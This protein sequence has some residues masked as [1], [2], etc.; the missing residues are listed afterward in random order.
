MLVVTSVLA[1][2]AVIEYY[3]SILFFARGG[4][5]NE[6]PCF[7]ND[8]HAKV[9]TYSL[10]S[11]LSSWG[12]ST[13]ALRKE[14]GG[15]LY[16]PWVPV[17]V[18]FWLSYKWLFY[19]FVMAVYPLYCLLVACNENR[20]K[21]LTGIPSHFQQNLL[22]PSHWMALWW[23]NYI[24]CNDM[25]PKDCKSLALLKQNTLLAA[26]EE[27]NL[28]TIKCIEGDVVVKNANVEGGM[29]IHFFKSEKYGGNC[30]IQC[31]PEL[32]ESLKDLLPLECHNPPP[33]F[34]VV[35]V[36]PVGNELDQPTKVISCV[37]E[38]FNGKSCYSVFYDVTGPVF[39]VHQATTKDKWFNNP[40]CALWK[41]NDITDRVNSI[42]IKG[43]GGASLPI[44]EQL[45]TLAE[46]AHHELAP[47]LPCAVWEIQLSIEGPIIAS[48]SMQTPHWSSLT[49][50][51]V[52]FKHY[53][54]QLQY[55]QVLPVE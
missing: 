19:V 22:N 23:T 14:F 21:N 55:N 28:P 33:R 26:A 36:S 51:P 8:H 20:L 7:K 27:S 32:H 11:V 31:T 29:G 4:K 10:G 52:L 50:T 13:S 12:K 54:S 30:V 35:T 49:P 38:V 34:H 24:C 25:V 39:S 16:L 44:V 42:N 43:L 2:A 48:L 45:F 1:A 9:H 46:N 37:L 17:P 41:K 6:C 5:F 40:L 3:R 47:G 18:S 53:S 15:H